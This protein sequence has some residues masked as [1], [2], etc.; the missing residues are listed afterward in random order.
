MLESQ[1]PTK[2]LSLNEAQAWLAEIAHAED[3]DPPLV[4]HGRLS[5]CT[6]AAAVP[7]HHTIV[8]ASKHPTQLTLLHELAHFMGSM[9]HGPHFQGSLAELL[10]RH[11]S[12]LHATT[13][14]SELQSVS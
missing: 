7:E 9:G 4:I 14:L 11:V 13:L 2:K 10:R 5:R 6:A 1:L 3:I 12:F 8:V